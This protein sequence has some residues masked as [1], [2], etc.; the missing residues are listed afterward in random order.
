MKLRLTTAALVGAAG[1]MG[2][3]LVGAPAQADTCLEGI[4]C[5][6]DV[7]FEVTAGALQITVPDDVTLTNNGAP[8]GYAYGQL[9][10]ILV[11]DLRAEAGVGWTTTVSSTDFTTGPGPVFGPGESIPNDDVYYCSG[12]GTT[13]GTGLFTPGQAGPC[14]AP[15]PPSGAALGGTVTA[16]S[17]D[18]TGTG[19]N[20]ALWDPLLTVSIPLATIAGPFTGTVT[21]SVS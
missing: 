7:T 3:L 11:E 2:S 9:G 4:G 21:H 15:P 5:T 6:T 17:H 18:T 16:Y 1:L 19:N 13:T 20:T 12:T 10:D 8:G 14:T